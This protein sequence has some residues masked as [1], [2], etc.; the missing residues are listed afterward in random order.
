M[1]NKD[2]KDLKKLARDVYLGQT[3]NFSISDAND[4]LRKAILEFMTNDRGEISYN[5]YK[6]N[7]YQLFAVLED[8]LSPVVKPYELP[9]EL[10]SLVSIQTIPYGDRAYVNV[11]DNAVFDLYVNVNGNA[12]I[13]RQTAIGGRLPVETSPLAIKI[14]AELRQFLAGEVDFTNMVNKVRTSFASGVDKRIGELFNNLDVSV[15]DAT[16]SFDPDKLA[17]LI[18]KVEDIYGTEA[19]IYGRKSVLGKVQDVVQS[20]EAKREFN[21]MG[22]FGSFRGTKMIDVPTKSDKLVI[23]PYTGSPLV[24]VIYEG[25]PLALDTSDFAQRNDL[26]IEFFFQQLVGV[27]KAVTQGATYKLD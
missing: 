26:Q 19:I 15:E 11:D 25:A 27:A 8:V 1:N 2:L 22:Y 23:V 24:V 18:E 16:G 10:S 3:G 5:I 13:R 7:Q 14:Y 20:D 6:Q 4:E 9:A 21:S 12:D 17:E